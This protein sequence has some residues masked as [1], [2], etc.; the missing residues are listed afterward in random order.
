MTPASLTL[1]KVP[2]MS[3]KE[4]SQ[5]DAEFK[6]SELRWRS[7]MENE[8]KKL[9]ALQQA[10]AEKY[11]A[12]IDMLVIREQGRQKLRE[13]IIEKTLGGAVWA[14]LIFL[15]AAVWQSVKEHVK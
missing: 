14:G 1:L 7:D 2:I 10:R 12:F 11:D 4:K 5:I 8:I 9:V 15:A 3:E 6:R 13:A